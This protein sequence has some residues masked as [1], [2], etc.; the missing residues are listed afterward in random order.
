MNIEDLTKKVKE[1][2]KK[3]TPEERT[4]LLRKANI[5]D[6]NGEFCKEY[7]SLRN[8]YVRLLREN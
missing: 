4:K 2:A 7:F 3:R 8:L 6:E 1:A 5:L